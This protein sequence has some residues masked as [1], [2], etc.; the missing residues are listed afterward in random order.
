MAVEITT[1]NGTDHISPTPINDNF[2]NVK[3]AVNALQSKIE[4]LDTAFIG[5]TT[6]ISSSNFKVV[7]VKF[8][9]IVQLTLTVN[10]S[11]NQSWGSENIGTLPEAWRPAVRCTYTH[12]GRD[13]SNMKNIYI[14]PNGAMSYQNS[15]GA[16]SNYGFI[17]TFMYISSK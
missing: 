13:N 14:D 3:S 2:N 5:S 1:I 17:E 16:Q 6:L 7:G 11:N 10:H 8:G 9:R 12:A 15:G 4:N